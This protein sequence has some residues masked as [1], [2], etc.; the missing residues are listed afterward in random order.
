MFEDTEF[1]SQDYA[2]P[3]GAQLLLYSDGAFELPLPRGHW[4]LS[5]FVEL[6]TSLAGTGDWTLDTL[7]AR[8]QSL[9]TGGLFDDDCSLVLA[10]FD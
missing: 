10:T 8:L 3:A 1:S 6:C 7:I 2:V 4:S 9:T 5:G